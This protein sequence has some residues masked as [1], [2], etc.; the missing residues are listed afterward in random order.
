[1][2]EQELN[3]IVGLLPLSQTRGFP[4]SYFKWLVQNKDGTPKNMLNYGTSYQNYESCLQNLRVLRGEGVIFFEETLI[5]Q[6]NFS[7]VLEY[8]QKEVNRYKHVGYITQITRKHR[9]K[10]DGLR[11]L[12][13]QEN[14]ENSES[15][16][17]TENLN[18]ER[19]P[20]VTENYT[21]TI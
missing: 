18:E 8:L 21:T 10:L 19:T 16:S 6:I 9:V 12:P 7:F 20:E 17:D 3:K 1:M 11:Q 14:P 15:S 13:I 2:S 5:T 4:V